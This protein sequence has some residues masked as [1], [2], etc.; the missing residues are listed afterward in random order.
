MTEWIVKKEDSRLKIVGPND[1][2][3]VPPNFLRAKIQSREQLQVLCDKFNLLKCRDI[4]SIV[5]FETHVQ[6]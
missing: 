6:G 3:Y 5:E 2:T 1:E 4:F